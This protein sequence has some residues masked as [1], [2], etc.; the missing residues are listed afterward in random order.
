MLSRVIFPAAAML[1]LVAGNIVDSP[2]DPI[3]KK[4]EKAL[5]MTWDNTEIMMTAMFPDGP[6]FTKYHNW[7]LDQIMD[8]NGTVNVCMRWNSDKVLDEETRNNIH[9][10]HVQQYEQWLQWLPGWDNFPF[11]EVKHNVIAWAVAN[12]SQLVGNRDGFHVYTEFKDE[13]GAPD[14]DPGCS[15][16]LHQDGDFSKCGRG[17][18]NRYQQYFLVDKAWGDYNMGSASGEGISV[19]EYGW[20]H[21]GSQLGNWSIL[22]HET[23]HTFGLRDYI[24]DHSNTTDIC[25]IMWLPPNLESQMVMEPTDQGAHIPMLSHYEGWLTRYLWSRFSRLRGWQED[26]TTYPPTP[27]CPPGSFK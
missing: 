27:K 15:R 3:P 13:N 18:E 14:C 4:W 16:H 12:D 9:A 10:Q 7:A 21:V 6:G 2:N 23:G 20:D 25:S 26:G 17:A 19:S 5:P 11:K 22:V 24:N 8:G 1:P